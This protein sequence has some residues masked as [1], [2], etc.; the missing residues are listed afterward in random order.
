MVGDFKNK[1]NRGIIPRTLNYLYE[2]ID[3]ILK[4]EGSKK[5]ESKFTISLSFI[6]LYLESIQDLID[7]G[8]KEIKIKED[9]ECTFKSFSCNINCKNRTF[10]KSCN[11][12]KS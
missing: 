1:K 2:Q 3:K 12:N 10:I 6:Q 8:Q 4:E 9:I 11:K 7:P 5:T